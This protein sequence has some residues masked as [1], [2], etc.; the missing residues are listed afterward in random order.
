[1]NLGDVDN[2]WIAISINFV[3]VF[4]TAIRQ[5]SASSRQSDTERVLERIASMNME[6]RVKIEVLER[7]F[8]ERK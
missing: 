6:Q 5:L 1:M 8:G 3:V 4:V 2:I 7:L